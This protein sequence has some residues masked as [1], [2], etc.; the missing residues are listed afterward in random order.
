MKR[1]FTCALAVSFSLVGA[2]NGSDS[3]PDA[4]ADAEGG[5]QPNGSD[6]DA[7]SPID[8]GSGATSPDADSEA[9]ANYAFL[10]SSLHTGDL[11]GVEGAD[12]ICNSRASEADLPGTYVAFLAT[13]DQTALERL[14]GARGWMRTD[15]RPLA[16][17]VEDLA[18]GRVFHPLN[19]FETGESVGLPSPSDYNIVW[20]GIDG[21]AETSPSRCQD[22]D[23]ADASES[24]Q[25]GESR[26]GATTF[27]TSFARACASPRP[28]YCFGTGEEARVEPEATGRLAFVTRDVVRGDAGRSEFDDVCQSEADRA[29]HDGS[30]L[31]AVDMSDS[32]AA[33]RFSLSGET[34]VRPDGAKVFADAADLEEFRPI[35]PIAVTAD[36]EDHLIESVWTGEN[37]N[38]D[39]WENAEAGGTSGRSDFSGHVG[40]SEGVAGDCSSAH[41]L[42]CF[43]F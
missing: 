19:V 5:G 43:E 36:G 18:V 15:G 1:H 27:M 12:E 42:Y 11:G 26:A 14:D 33:D 2:C 34:W 17:R 39:D 7:S 28:I 31:A 13:D 10:T 4:V 20:T 29:G 6:L 3:S 35:T 22:W 38:C 24:G 30:F 41:R 32:P 9:H 25:T 8:G 37:E 21:A 16:D 40:R 23:S